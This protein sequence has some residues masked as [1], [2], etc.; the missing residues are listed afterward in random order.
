MRIGIDCRMYGLKHAGI[1]RYVLNLVNNLLP[2]DKE[3]DYVLLVN[4]D[5]EREVESKSSKIKIVT[6]NARHYSLKEQLLLPFILYRE[7]LDLVHFPHF[8]VP[9]L[10][11]KKFV[12]TIHDLIKHTSK[13]VETTTRSPWVY[14]LKYLGYKIVFWLTVKRAERI[15]VP[16]QAVKN[17]LR[18]EYGLD[19]QKVRVTYEG[20]D[21]N[22]KN[23][24]NTTAILEKYKIKKPYLLYVG[25]VYPH[26]NI[27]KL[28][29]AI[30]ILNHNLVVVCAR[31]VFWER[32]KEKVVQLK[33]ENLVTLAGF[34]PDSELGA[35][36]HQAEA[37][38][39]PSLSEGFGL[40]GLE[41]MAQGVAVAASDIPVFKEVYKDAAVYFEPEDPED[42]ADK[43]KKLLSDKKLQEQLKEQGSKLVKQ[44][45]WKKMAQETLQ[46]YN[47]SLR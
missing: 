22:I 24:S 2:L 17:D 39:F 47:S 26:K 10:Y 6:V 4:K 33:A 8:N 44:Y 35:L 27:A 9:V 42:I 38:V 5:F 40:P 7:K 29:Q 16:C 21:S 41:A 37:F 13:G 11:F 43:I 18:R 31:S 20:F 46:V 23:S 12:V 1:G 25:S 34:V 36:Y 14:W 32:L 3:N 15:M 45:S 19:S 30:K 28:I